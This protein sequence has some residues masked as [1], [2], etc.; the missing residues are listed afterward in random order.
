M[1]EEAVDPDSIYVAGLSAGGAMAAVMAAAYPDLYAAVGVH[2]GLA[3]G[4]AH[5]VASAFG[6]MRG[7]GSPPPPAGELPLIVFHGDR[8]NVV[9]PVNAEKIIASRIAAER[10]KSR[11][12]S[13]HGRTTTHQPTGLCHGYTRAIYRDGDDRS[14]AEQW[15]VHGG[16]HAWFGGSPEGSF[17]DS[18]GPDASAEMVRFFLEQ[19]PRRSQTGG[20]GRVDA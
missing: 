2:S 4:A 13:V 16:A 7:G 18:H 14:V 20:G 11:G 5:D 8:D 6:A 3:A 17:T 1:N 12:S 9:A 15:T 10:N 19:S